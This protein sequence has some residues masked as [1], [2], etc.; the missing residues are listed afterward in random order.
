MSPQTKTSPKTGELLMERVPGE[1]LISLLHESQSMVD[2]TRQILE[3]V[4]SED[5]LRMPGIS[6]PVPAMDPQ[7]TS[8]LPECRRIKHLD[9]GIAK[10]DAMRRDRFELP[11]VWSPAR[12]AI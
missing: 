10:I 6:I 3:I 12:F 7:F 1:G 4:R 9:L 11:H 8:Q 5:R 2:H